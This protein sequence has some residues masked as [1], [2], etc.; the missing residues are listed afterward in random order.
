MPRVTIHRRPEICH[1]G[2]QFVQNGG[3]KD[4]TPFVEI[5]EE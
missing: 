1:L 2:M 4:P 5:V 3:E